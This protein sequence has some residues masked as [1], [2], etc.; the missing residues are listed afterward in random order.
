MTKKK[1]IDFAV[2][3]YL[4]A[5]TGFVK[6]SKIQDIVSFDQAVRKARSL[7]RRKDIVGRIGELMVA[8]AN[9]GFEIICPDKEI[10]KFY[11]KWAAEININLPDRTPSGLDQLLDW[12]FREYWQSGLVIPYM[13]WG[14]IEGKN[15][16]VTA[17]IM[18]PLAIE[19]ESTSVFGQFKYRLRS[20]E[21][22]KELSLYD[23]SFQELY[24]T[25]RENTD[26]STYLPLRKDDLFLVLRRAC[27]PYE[28]FPTPY[29]S[30]VF[31]WVDLRDKLVE[32]DWT[33]ALGVIL[34]VILFKIMTGN[35]K[36]KEKVQKEILQNVGRLSVIA[37]SANIETEVIAPRTDTL[38]SWDKYRE[39]DL[40]IF[41]SLGLL[42]IIGADQ[43][44]LRARFNPK[45][46][47]AEIE[48]ARR[49]VKR[50]MERIFWEIAQKNNFDVVPNLKWKRLRLF[51]D[52]T[53]WKTFVRD[54][55][56][57]G[58]LSQETYA[59]EAEADYRQEVERRKE[60]QKY[61]GIMEPR[62][63]F[64]QGVA[65][66]SGGQKTVGV[67][68]GAGRPEGTENPDEAKAD[69]STEN[70]HHIEN[71]DCPEDGEF[72]G[73]IKLGKSGILGRLIKLPSGSTAIKVYLFPKDKFTMEEAKKWVEEH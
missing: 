23:R 54:L 53:A 64:R 63:T 24:L 37:T 58:V 16:P 20:E 7:W 15:F 9:N 73:T 44:G 29:L 21:A 45:P 43:T 28:P 4:E 17:A 47:I 70:Y 13:T 48:Y 57:R 32:M 69:F 36:D 11:D 55:Y 72:V 41:E 52:Q 71:P 5:L 68:P 22:L 40:M 35:P 51:E 33:T 38:L 14:E 61:A 62:V 31:Q 3:S 56:D 65:F 19:I 34:S 42:E 6:N 25:P 12:I 8:S 26:S 27:Q 18:N 67:P 2:A 39:C 46:M 10:K 30:L 50:L 49:H 66:P 60:E 59:D 1:G